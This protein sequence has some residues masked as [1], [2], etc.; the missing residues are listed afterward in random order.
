[1]RSVVAC[2]DAELGARL[3]TDARRGIHG[4]QRRETNATKGVPVVAAVGEAA[5]G[6]GLLLAPSFVGELPPSTELTGIAVTVARVAGIAL[7]ALAVASRL[8]N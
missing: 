7:I 4:A 3:R 5:K 6:V 2:S 8:G 1:M